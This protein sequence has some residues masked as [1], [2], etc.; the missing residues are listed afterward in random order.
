[1]GTVLFPQKLY[2][3]TR[4]PAVINLLSLFLYPFPS[5]GP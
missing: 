2:D 5:V 1:M 3:S 4:V